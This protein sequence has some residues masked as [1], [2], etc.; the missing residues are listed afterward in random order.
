VKVYQNL[1][2]HR[3]STFYNCFHQTVMYFLFFFIILRFNF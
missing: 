2:T 1:I 3:Y